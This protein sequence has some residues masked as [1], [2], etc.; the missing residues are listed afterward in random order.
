[1]LQVTQLSSNIV[2]LNIVAG[3]VANA[4][5]DTTSLSATNNLNLSTVKTEQS[6]ATQ[7]LVPD[8]WRRPRRCR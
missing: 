1:M 7:T 4:G 5:T 3:V 8:A 6:N 2:W